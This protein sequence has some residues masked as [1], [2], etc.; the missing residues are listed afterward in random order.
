VGHEDFTFRKIRDLPYGEHVENVGDLY[1]PVPL[2]DA[3]PSVVVIHGGGWVQSDKDQ[4]RERDRAGFLAANG[5]V[6][7]SINYRLGHIWPQHLFDSRRAVRFLRDNAATY[8]LNGLVGA[9]GS[10]AGGHL[11][12]ALAVTDGTDFPEE[13]VTGDIGR[14][15]ATVNCRS[16]DPSLGDGHTPLCRIP[17]T[18]TMDASPI[19]Y[20]SADDS[21]VDRARNR[22]PL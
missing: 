22:R 1:L 12:T 10:S 21:G 11:A 6:T 19:K 2:G 17:V 7:Y 9:M 15:D 4:A 18:A 5:F 14:V 16:M 20:A 8:H 3:Q 13:G